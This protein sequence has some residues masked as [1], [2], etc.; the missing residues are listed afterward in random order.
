M[1]YMDFLAIVRTY[2]NNFFYTLLY[3]L[4]TLYTFVYKP[5]LICLF[6]LCSS[7]YVIKNICFKTS[8]AQLQ[9][10][11]IKG[12]YYNNIILNTIMFKLQTVAENENFH[13]HYFA[14]IACD[15]IRSIC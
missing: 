3:K 15:N 1:I 6:S 4:Y 12:C 13:L 8:R 5:M 10:R 9:A 7:E 11:N 14:Y 2:E